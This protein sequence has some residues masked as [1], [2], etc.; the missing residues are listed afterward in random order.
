MAELD[1]YKSMRW[2]GISVAQGIPQGSRLG[3]PSQKLWESAGESKKPQKH[4]Y[5]F[6]A[7]PHVGQR[8]VREGRLRD[9]EE[10]ARICS[11][12]PSSSGAAERICTPL[13]P[14]LWQGIRVVTGWHTIRD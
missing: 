8:G 7:E 14:G 5:V 6:F 9:E 11:G 1:V 13:E 12:G 10:E 3:G 4:G 2:V